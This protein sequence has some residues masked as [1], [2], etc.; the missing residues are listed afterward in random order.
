M[1]NVFNGIEYDGVDGMR[2][3]IRSQYLQL[4]LSRMDILRIARAIVVCP[5]GQ[6]GSGLPIRTNVHGVQ[7]YELWVM[8]L[9]LGEKEQQPPSVCLAHTSLA[10]SLAGMAAWRNLQTP[11]SMSRSFQDSWSSEA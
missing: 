11:N 2:P 9:S 6:P 1:K 10:N 5:S 4:P 3:E 7:Q 8:T